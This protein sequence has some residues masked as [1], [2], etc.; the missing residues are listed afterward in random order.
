[1]GK[2]RLRYEMSNTRLCDNLG[3]KLE[4]GPLSFD[5]LPD[6]LSMTA[7]GNKTGHLN[8]SQKQMQTT[9]YCESLVPFNM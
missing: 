9:Q 3:V 8:L 7:L 6:V 5:P 2:P 4:Q 1:M